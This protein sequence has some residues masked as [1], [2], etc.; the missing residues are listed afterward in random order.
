MRLVSNFQ[1]VD[2]SVVRLKGSNY[3]TKYDTLYTVYRDSNKILSRTIHANGDTVHGWK[4]SWLS[5]RLTSVALK[6][7]GENNVIRNDILHFSFGYFYH[8]LLEI[9]FQFHGKIIFLRIFLMDINGILPASKINYIAD[10]RRIL[11]AMREW[12]LIYF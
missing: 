8:S 12:N 3:I 10:K 7:K 9:Q 5:D 6:G 11:S 4:H 2:T 1:T